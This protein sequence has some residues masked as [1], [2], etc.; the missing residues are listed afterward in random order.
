MDA[1]GSAAGAFI[2]LNVVSGVLHSG[3]VLLFLMVPNGAFHVA[4]LSR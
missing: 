3:K 2:P 1:A 4:P